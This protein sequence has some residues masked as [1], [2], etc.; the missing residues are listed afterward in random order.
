M[1]LGG[2]IVNQLVTKHLH[3]SL[4]WDLRPSEEM[5]LSVLFSVHPDF[6]CPGA[7]LWR[8]LLSLLRSLCYLSTG[9]AMRL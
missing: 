5:A 7:A 2:V 6:S 3:C 4:W 8:A 9:L 1:G